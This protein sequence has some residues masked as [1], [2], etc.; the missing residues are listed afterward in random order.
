L[1]LLHFCV[2]EDDD[3]VSY[4]L[5]E[6]KIDA[7][8]ADAKLANFMTFFRAKLVSGD[9]SDHLLKIFCEDAAAASDIWKMVAL[10]GLQML[11]DL[12]ANHITFIASHGY[13]KCL[14]QMIVESDIHLCK[15]LN[16][17]SLLAPLFVY[18]TKMTFLCK[19]AS[20][21]I[22]AETLLDKKVLVSLS[23]MDV[24][25]HHPT[26]G[27]SST[28]SAGSMEFL[29]DIGS[30]YLKLFVPVLKLCNSMIMSLGCKNKEV[31]SQ[32]MHLIFSLNETVSLILCSATPNIMPK[33]M[34]ELAELT[35]TISP[36]FGQ[37][38][39]AMSSKEEFQSEKAVQIHKIQRLMLSL[40]TNFRL[41]EVVLQRVGDN[42]DPDQRNAIVRS[43]AT[44]HYL[45]VRES[46][47]D[48]VDNSTYGS[49]R[50]NRKRFFG[51]LPGHYSSTVLRSKYSLRR[52]NG[53]V[54]IELHI[55]AYAE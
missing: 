51:V 36:V 20:T 11:I 54:Y 37:Y 29:R 17:D 23:T 38:S 18:K 27:V 7:K 5:D 55:P 3:E 4:R 49:W 30:K 21:L 48:T 45:Q 43:Q 2:D 12:D 22:G 53:T 28:S 26:V 33:Y 16:Q 31:I 41:S 10:S 13:L 44:V 6:I 8:D 46:D 24:F 40:F 9:F 1:T 39:A 19:I 15:L 50:I 35:S 52:E 42:A 34:K 47:S 32:V 14:I 25:N